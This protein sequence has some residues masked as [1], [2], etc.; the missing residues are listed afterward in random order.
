MLLAVNR[1]VRWLLRIVG[2]LTLLA[3]IGLG[4]VF[5]SLR[6]VPQFYDKAMRENAGDLRKGSDQLLRQVTALQGVVQRPGHWRVRFT[7]EQI[8]GWLA[9]DLVEN[10]PHVLPPSLSDARVAIRPDGMRLGCRLEEGLTNCVLSLAIRPSVPEADTAA[11][12]LQRARAGALP[13][14]LR[15]VIER[16]SQAARAMHLQLRWGQAGGDPVAVVALPGEYGDRAAR[17]DAIEL[18]DGWIE[19]SGTTGPRKQAKP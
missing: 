8:N 12:R 3:V 5:V 16:L 11:L 2:C 10:Y 7:A 13:I 19:L 17:I 4:V 9:V 18:G 1:R 15:R 14:P 6:H